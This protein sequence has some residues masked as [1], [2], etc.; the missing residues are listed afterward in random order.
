MI[1]FEGMWI[2]GIRIRK[3]VE[4]LKWDLRTHSGRN[5]EDSCTEDD[6]NCSGLTQEISEE[7]NFSILPRDSFCD[8]LVKN[9]AAFCSCLKPD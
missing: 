7:K 2:W 5:M 8:I 1:L 3:A 4:C 6:L 9:V